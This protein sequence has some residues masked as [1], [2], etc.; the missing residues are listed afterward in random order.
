MSVQD[1]KDT[2][3][4]TL[5][6]RLAAN[7]PGRTIALRGVT[8]PALLVAENELPAI[9]PATP[10]AFTMQWTSLSVD[11]LGMAKLTCEIRYATAGSTGAAGMDRGRALAA[12]DAELRTAVSAEPQNTPLIALT[13]VQG[14]GA[15][16]QTSVGTSIFWSGAA[17]GPTLFRDERLE[18]I[19]TVEVFGYE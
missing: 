19:A 7:N 16:T 1:V 12:M 15:I 18:R 9:A 4:L 6:D 13:E 14:G 17:F 2:F 8:R 5:R 3:Y 11:L 10:D